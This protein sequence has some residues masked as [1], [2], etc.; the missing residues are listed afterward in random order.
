MFQKLVKI[1]QNRYP[2]FQILKMNGHD[3][4]DI[5]T[6][7]D[8]RHNAVG[9]IARWI[10]RIEKNK[11]RKIGQP[12][13]IINISPHHQEYFNEIDKLMQPYKSYTLK[14]HQSCSKAISSRS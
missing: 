3:I 1:L 7:K 14:L 2:G 8:P 13:T 4:I 9:L 11:I 10:V 6:E 12:I 5:F